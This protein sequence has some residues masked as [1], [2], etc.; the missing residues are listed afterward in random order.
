MRTGP[1]PPRLLSLAG[2][3]LLYSFPIAAITKAHRCSG[4]HNTHLLLDSSGGQ[5]SEM[6]LPGIHQGIHWAVPLKFRGG[7]VAWPFPASR[8][9]PCSSACGSLLY[10]QSQQ[11]STEPLSTYLTDSDHPPPFFASKDFCDYSGLIQI[12]QDNLI[13][14]AL[15]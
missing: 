12:S 1:H 10:L 9:C 6:G 3:F 8:S 11:C 4:L 7:S 5:K 2:V 13:S 15:S 14:A